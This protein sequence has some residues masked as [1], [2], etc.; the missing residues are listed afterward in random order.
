MIMENPPKSVKDF[1]IP[2]ED[3]PHIPQ[4]FTLRQAIAIVR[5]AAIKFEGSFE[6]RAVLVFDE[7]YRLRGILTLLDLVKALQPEMSAPAGLKTP[8]AGPQDL[9]FDFFGPDLEN[10][11][12][13]PVSDVMSPIRVT[14]NSND[15]LA[16][17]L[18]LMIKENL[19]RIPV[20]EGERVAGMIRLGDLFNEIAQAIL[21]R[22]SFPDRE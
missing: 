19:V 13:R 20:L 9:L 5:E 11:L 4:W 8:G 10:Q 17:A 14:V 18:H 3:Y 15:P 7:K 16:L 6:P 12:Q 22:S 2:L 1:M 21:V